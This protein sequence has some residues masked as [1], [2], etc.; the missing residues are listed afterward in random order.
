MT[1]S[2]FES[3]ECEKNKWLVHFWKESA[4]ASLWTQELHIPEVFLYAYFLVLLSGCI[5][6]YAFPI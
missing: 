6:T 5:T 3:S 1:A 2:Y 4:E